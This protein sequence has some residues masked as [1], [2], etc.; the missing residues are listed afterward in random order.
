MGV[1]FD[2]DGILATG[3]FL[4]KNFMLHTILFYGSCDTRA[5]SQ[6][7]SALPNNYWV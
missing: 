7:L 5:K 3:V 6:Y 1:S 2:Q 4:F